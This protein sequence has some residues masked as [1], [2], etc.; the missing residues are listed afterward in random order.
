MAQQTE[1]LI[2][3]VYKERI[4]SREAQIKQLQAQINPH[5]LYNCLFFINNMNRMGNDEAVTAMTQNLAEYFRYTPRLNEPVTTLEKEIG[6]VRNYQNI[7]CLRMNRLQYDIDI[8]EA[9]MRLTVPK[10]SLQPLVENSIIHGIEKKQSAGK[11]RISGAMEGNRCR[12]VVEDDGKGMEPEEI[13]ALLDRIAQPPDDS[14]GCALWNIRQRMLIHFSPGSGLRIEPIRL[15]G[16]RVE[17]VWLLPDL[18][19]A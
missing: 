13:A 2:E 19:D 16:L 18:P 15:G 12:L 6:V 7:Q 3:K 10:L 5:F 14:M 11:I 17:L 9:M 1:E 4:A 8:P